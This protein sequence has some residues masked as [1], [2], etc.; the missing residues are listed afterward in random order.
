MKP[1]T[2]TSEVHSLGGGGI[3][4]VDERRTPTNGPE[5]KKAN[6]DAHVLTSKR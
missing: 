5:N 2:S 1:A 4:E 6:E 3:L